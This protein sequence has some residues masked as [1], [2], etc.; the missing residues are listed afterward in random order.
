MTS[1]SVKCSYTILILL[2]FNGGGIALV[3]PPIN[4]NNKSIYFKLI[5]SHT[6]PTVCFQEGDLGVSV[7]SGLTFVQCNVRFGIIAPNKSPI[8]G[9]VYQ[10]HLVSFGVGMQLPFITLPNFTRMNAKTAQLH[11]SSVV[12]FYCF[13]IFLGLI[14]C[15]GKLEKHSKHRRPI[16][17]PYKSEL[18]FMAASPQVKTNPDTVI[19]DQIFMEV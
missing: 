17:P 8:T 10:N 1:S 11:K 19:G 15:A 4:P 9:Y 2:S 3:Y 14:S 12:L 13:C 7:K 16:N 5:D 6:D 18:G